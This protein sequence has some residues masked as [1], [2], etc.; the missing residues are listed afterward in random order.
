M[1]DDIRQLLRNWPYNPNQRVRLCADDNGR[2][3]IQIR[4]PLGI[5]QYEADGRPDGEKPGGYESFLDY[6]SAQAVIAGIN[7]PL[8]YQI[9]DRAFEELRNEG[10]MLYYRYSALYSLKDYQR[11][12]RD[13]LANL[14]LCDFLDK[15]YL[16]SRRY[17]VTQFRPFIIRTNA[18]ATADNLIIK[19]S[20]AEA[21]ATIEQAIQQI[22]STKAIPTAA[23]TFESIKAVAG[24]HQKLALLQQE[25]KSSEHAIEQLQADLAAA[26]ESEDYERAAEIRDMLENKIRKSP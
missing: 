4:L 25:S 17:E 24:L 10:I 3:Y 14:A 20:Y 1:N 15:H 6:C 22:E 5:E 19:D 23:Y 12:Q 16:Q 7:S 18:L 8:P 9:D 11:V 13:T 26:I 21:R 2:W